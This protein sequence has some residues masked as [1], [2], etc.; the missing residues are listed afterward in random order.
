[1]IR[2]V[3]SDM[4]GT[5]LQKNGR[6]SEK[7]VET[8]KALQKSGVRFVV[9]TGR[10]Y[11]DARI[12]LEEK[13]ISCDIICMNGSA[14]YNR[15]GQQIHRQ[16]LS[17]GQVKFIMDCCKEE[18]VFDFM[19]D[20]GSCTLTTKEQFAR[21]F[22]AGLL[23]PMAGGITYEYIVSRFHFLT[24]EELFS[25]GLEFYKMSII[26]PNPFVL[27]RVKANLGENTHLAVAASHHTN[28]EVTNSAAQKGLALLK[29][30]QMKGIRSKEIMA[31]GDSENDLSMLSLPLGYTIAMENSMESIK[32]AA[33]CMTRSNDEDGV[34]YAIETLILEDTRQA[35]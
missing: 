30:A 10:G 16:E 9:C 27:E 8:I 20:R 15:Q 32:Q 22:K 2:L 25:S 3:A 5:L 6:I 17:T 35:C 7:T 4:D 1:M 23:L 34:A 13:G 12:P 24:Q 29:Y 28:L 18:V 21:Y 31:I 11:E 14:V 19:T 26:H 33:R